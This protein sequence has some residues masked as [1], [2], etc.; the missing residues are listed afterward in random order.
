MSIWSSAAAHRRLLL[1]DSV[2]KVGHGMRNRKVEASGLGFHVA[3]SEKRRFNQPMSRQFGQTDFFTESTDSCLSLTQR[4]KITTHFIC[5]EWGEY[6]MSDSARTTVTC[7]DP[8]AGS[9]DVIIEL[10]KN[11]LAAMNVGLGDSLTIELVGGSIV[12][13]PIRDADTES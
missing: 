10:P 12:L 1:T 5:Q 11:V 4:R 7:Q 13:K 6:P 2:E 3:A 9:G 8:C